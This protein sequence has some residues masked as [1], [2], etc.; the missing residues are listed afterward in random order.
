[1]KTLRLIIFVIT[2][3]LVSC[4][5][6]VNSMAFFPDT[7]TSIPAEKMPSYL[8]EVYIITGDSVR[9][10]SYLLQHK[11]RSKRIVVYFHGNAG[12]IS[13]RVRDA[14]KIYR[15]GCDVLLVSY[16]GYGRSEGSPSERG[17]Y[18]DGISSINYITQNLGYT[19]EEI[20]IYGRSLGTAVAVYVA[21]NRNI[22]HLVL[23]TPLSSGREYAQAR[24]FGLLRACAGNSFDS[25]GR[26]N[27][28]SCPLL[29][30]HGDRDRVIPRDMGLRLY[31]AYRGEKQFVTI[32]GGGH[33]DLQD[34]DPELF[35]S[36]ISDLINK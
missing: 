8:R 31:R 25:L 18:E 4:E 9:L 19:E 22:S 13:H 29:I 34:A 2:L 33:N 21:Q 30:I 15:L 6:L 5:S 36:S 28:I 10:Q 35:W 1:M 26:I 12:N 11:G 7:R 3:A 24:G 32:N 20:I 17:V 16:R 14:S 27:N 23:V